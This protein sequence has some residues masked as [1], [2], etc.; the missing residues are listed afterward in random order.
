MT[1][2]KDGSRLLVLSSTIGRLDQSKQTSEE[3]AYQH[4]TN[5]ARCS[6]VQRGM[7]CSHIDRFQLADGACRRSR[8]PERHL[9]TRREID[10]IVGEPEGLFYEG[11]AMGHD[12]MLYFSDLTIT[13]AKG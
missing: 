6:S 4:Q 7:R 10:K 13:P 3:E 11:P 2:V 1:R 9:C 5:P 8:R 12:G